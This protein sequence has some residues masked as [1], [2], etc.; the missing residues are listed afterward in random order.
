MS[1]RHAVIL[2]AGAG[3]RLRPFLNDRPKGL[4]EIEG[5]SLMARSVALL[6]GAGIERI[7]IV[8]GYRADLYERFA[9]GAPDLQLLYND[10]Y[11]RTGSMA[12]LAIA[13]DVL[14]GVDL[15]VLESDIVYEARAL[16]VMLRSDADA[17]LLSG[18]TGA[19]DEVW[20]CAP[21]GRLTGISKTRSE[22]P[23]VAGELV[24]ITRLSAAAA[25]AMRDAY[26][27]FVDEH[28]HGRMAYETDGLVAIADRIRI[29]A[30]LVSDL[31]WGEIDDER[32]YARIVQHVWP[33]VSGARERVQ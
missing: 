7:T 13:L 17:T 11:E 27:R 28:G 19:G 21:H 23:S 4:L 18:P 31:C 15:L 10:A 16:E 3:L 1:V 24:G 14:R 32:H 22:L 6:R 20:V 33:I 5:E 25:D 26:R 2:A 9:A 8:T 29:A 30:P 12:S